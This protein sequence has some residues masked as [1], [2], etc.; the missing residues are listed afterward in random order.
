MCGV[1]GIQF[2]NKATDFQRAL[3]ILSLAD[4]M[5]TR[6]DQS[7]GIFGIQ[8]KKRAA[9]TI[10]KDIGPITGA[11]MSRWSRYSIIAGHTRWATTGKVIAANAHPFEIGNTI[12]MHNGTL[13]CHEELNRKYNRQFAV[14]SMHLVA[15]VDEQKDLTEVASYGTLVFAR[16]TD[17]GAVYLG[18]WNDGDLAVWETP[19]GVVWASTDN[20]IVRALLAAGV[21][22]QD[23]RVQ[24]IRIDEETLYVIANGEV[25]VQAKKFFTCQRRSFRAW[26][27]G[28][29]SGR[30][31]RTWDE[32]DESDF[33]P[34]H[35]RH[36]S[37]IITGTGGITGSAA[38]T[39][40]G[41]PPRHVITDAS[42]SGSAALREAV[43]GIVKTDTKKTESDKDLIDVYGSDIPDDNEP[44]INL[45]QL[46]DHQF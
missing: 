25:R 40:S 43:R 22:P 19:V 14:D 44:G 7:W 36:G 28:R 4:E 27:A 5:E 24:P 21:D 18:R 45:N 26:D 6:G 35:G 16:K 32:W 46:D 42:G 1:F 12:G 41:L 23:D 3:M 15:H 39:G 31:R 29:T 37:T 9:W 2:T 34:G 8:R 17:D 33:L 38:V 30:G 13:S 20:A 11:D 10:E